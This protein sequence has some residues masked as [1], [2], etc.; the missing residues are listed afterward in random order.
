[1]YL[2]WASDDMP[3]N[4]RLR[5]GRLAKKTADEFEEIWERLRTSVDL[6]PN[7]TEK[8]RADY[9]D[10]GWMKPQD[11]IK[12]AHQS[13]REEVFDKLAGYGIKPND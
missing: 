3:Q 7:L 10:M 2:D 5:L 11:Y 4:E 13:L 12:L 1:M 9:H 8:E 6:Y